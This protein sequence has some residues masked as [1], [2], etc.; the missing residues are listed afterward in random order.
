MK[1]FSHYYALPGTIYKLSSLE[2]RKEILK[3]LTNMCQPYIISELII[4]GY[5]GAIFSV[6]GIF[7]NVLCT[8]VLSSRTMRGSPINRI[9]LALAIADL[10]FASA[11]LFYQSLRTLIYHYCLSFAFTLWLF[12][13]VLPFVYPIGATG[14]HN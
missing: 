8:I 1:L 5:I 3:L 10:C 9:L 4:E 2:Q 13:L 7:G 12:P 6:F 14:E 11:N